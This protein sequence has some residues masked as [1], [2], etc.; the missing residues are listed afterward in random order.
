MSE[1]FHAAGADADAS[2]GAL[3]GRHVVHA[4]QALR[5]VEQEAAARRL[6]CA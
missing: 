2:A 5:L 3:R 4:V 6:P 1:T